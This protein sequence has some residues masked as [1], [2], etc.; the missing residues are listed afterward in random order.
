MGPPRWVQSDLL[1]S[2]TIPLV[3]TVFDLLQMTGDTPGPV[4]HINRRD[5]PPGLWPVV[6]S[7]YDWCS[8]FL[9]TTLPPLLGRLAD[10]SFFRYPPRSSSLIVLCR[11]LAGASFSILDGP[12]CTFH[13]DPRLYKL[14]RLYNLWH[15]AFHQVLDLRRWT[16]ARF[17][18]PP[19]DASCQ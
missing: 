1:L 16:Y 15:A 9:F 13:Q 6:V 12:S 3:S 19:F 5:T 4:P 18:T 10:P 14:L 7:P 17:W 2:L 11:M 8:H